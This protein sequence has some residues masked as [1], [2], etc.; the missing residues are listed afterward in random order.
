MTTQP[1]AAPVASAS[2]VVDPDC[3]RR[4]A[5][6]ASFGAAR[7]FV[8]FLIGGVPAAVAS[9]LYRHLWTST[10][11]SPADLSVTVVVAVVVFVVIIGLMLLIVLGT[12]VP[13]MTG[14]YSAILPPGST[15]TVDYY[16]DRMIATSAGGAV[17]ETQYATMQRVRVTRHAVVFDRGPGAG[18]LPIEVV[19][20]AARQLLG[21]GAGGTR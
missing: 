1:G 20:P 2:I 11:D 6:S 14:M 4:I 5:R 12:L 3:A 15:L 7:L 18:V 9:V 8:M 13:R 17:N 21:A 10:H 16:P 19:P